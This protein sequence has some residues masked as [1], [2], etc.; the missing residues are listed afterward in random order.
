MDIAVGGLHLIITA[1]LDPVSLAPRH[2]LQRF[3]QRELARRDVEDDRAR[4]D[5][6]RWLS[7][8]HLR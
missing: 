7:G 4:W 6:T 1:R 8:P 2:A 5:R 3:Y